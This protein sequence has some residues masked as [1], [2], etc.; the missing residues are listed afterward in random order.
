MKKVL[1]LIL[2]ITAVIIFAGC[3]F[4]ATGSDITIAE[5]SFK[6]VSVTVDGVEQV[7]GTT[8][9]DFT[10]TVTYTVTDEDG[11]VSNYVVIV[12]YEFPFLR[13]MLSFKFLSKNN[14]AL[15]ATVVEEIDV[16]TITLKVPYGTDKTSLVP[17]FET[18]G[19]DVIVN[20]ILQ[21]SGVTPK[22]FSDTVVYTVTAADGSTCDYYIDVL[23]TVNRS[24]LD[25]M[26][27]DGN[28]VSRVDTSGITNMNNLF[29]FKT[30]F[31][32]D[33]SS[34]NVSSVI[35]MGWMFATA[36]AFSQDL[37]DWDVDYRDDDRTAAV[38]HT[39]FSHGWGGGTEPNWVP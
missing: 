7:S 18:N 6:D 10:S 27:A 25:T 32:Q 17:S 5:F 20:N 19:A 22:D 12:G 35:N 4:A 36:S 13:E 16:D 2:T 23:M 29:Y 38:L 28:D 15:D 14:T 30:S 8:L 33:I 24:Q 26:I 31:N 11:S 34:W 21:I 9:N 3:P 39:D 1:H 37:S